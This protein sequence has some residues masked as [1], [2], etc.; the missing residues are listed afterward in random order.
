MVFEAYDED[1]NEADFLCGTKP[2]PLFRIY[3][4][5]REEAGS[6][7]T[8]EAKIEENLLFY[9]EYNE[10]FG[11]IDIEYAVLPYSTIT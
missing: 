11:S 8:K 3:E 5:C 2:F 9:D 4:R 1:P 7:R 10:Y 6:T